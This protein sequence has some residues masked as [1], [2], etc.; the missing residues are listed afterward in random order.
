[1]TRDEAI[2]ELKCAEDLIK[3]DGKDWLDERDIPLLHMAIRS[4]EAWGNCRQALE[5]YEEYVFHN[6]DNK[7]AYAGIRNTVKGKRGLLFCKKVT[8]T[9]RKLARRKKLKIVKAQIVKYDGY[10]NS[11]TIS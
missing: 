6:S 5:E 2:N 3:Q 4:L 9:I 1:M 11:L 7:S 8:P 10:D